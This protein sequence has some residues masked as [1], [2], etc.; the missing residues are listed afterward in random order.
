MT[1]LN[2]IGDAFAKKRRI[3]LPEA[4]GDSAYSMMGFL[5]EQL[6]RHEMEQIVAVDRDPDRLHYW[7]SRGLRTI[8]EELIALKPYPSDRL[9]PTS[10]EFVRKHAFEWRVLGAKHQTFEL[11]DKRVAYERMA[12]TTGAVLLPPLL[13]R[14]IARE[15]LSAGGRGTTDTKDTLVTAYVPHRFKVVVDMNPDRNH[16]LCRKVFNE[17]HGRD[18]GALLLGIASNEYLRVWEAAK[19][20]VERLW[21]SGLCHL[22]MIE[23]Y[24]GRLYFIE[25]AARLSGSSWLFKKVGASPLDE[26][27]VVTHTTLVTTRC[28]I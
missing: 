26:S 12:K 9:L 25:V 17:V 3:L 15:V 10:E 13:P 18:D 20:V 23:D 4:G 7:R 27:R 24:D 21:L 11:H 8:T 5:S 19:E 22:Q 6:S 28:G 2:D 1:L 16:Y 14:A